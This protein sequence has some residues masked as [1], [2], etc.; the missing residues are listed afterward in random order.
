MDMNF[1]QTTKNQ[2]TDFYS[3]M[4]FSAKF[5]REVTVK[6][7][8][9]ESKRCMGSTPKQKFSILRFFALL[10]DVI[11][12]IGWKVFEKY[13]YLLHLLDIPYWLMERA[14]N[15]TYAETVIIEMT[16]CKPSRSDNIPHYKTHKITHINSDEERSD[17]GPPNC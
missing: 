16:R 6:M 10:G 1:D 7:A 11:D 3:R 12:W 15:D 17:H 9:E 2:F 8:A 4:N 14:S 5:Y 13:I